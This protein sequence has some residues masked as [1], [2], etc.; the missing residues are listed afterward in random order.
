VIL[1]PLDY[2]PEDRPVT[3]KRWFPADVTLPDG[4][5]LTNVLAIATKTR[6]YVW[7]RGTGRGVE[8]VYVAEHTEAAASLRAQAALP[9]GATRIEIGGDGHA[10]IRRGSG[11]GC[12]DPL[13]TYQPWTPARS[14]T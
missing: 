5:L 3:I 14:G 2:E 13:K 9:S 8:A 12:S 6:L 4:R 11:C 7:T 10:V 1:D